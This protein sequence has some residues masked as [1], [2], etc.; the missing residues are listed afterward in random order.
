[1]AVALKALFD[2][3]R[4]AL[5]R[6]RFR[7]WWEGEAFDEGAAVAEIEAGLAAAND[8]A[9]DFDD[10]LFDAPA[11][12]PPPR[13]VAL[14]LLWGE[15]RIRPGDSTADKLEP[16]RIGLAPEGVLAVLGPGHI[17]PLAAVAAAHP[18]QIEVFEWREETFEALKHA[19]A[20]AEL[21]GRI[22]ASRID[23]EAHVFTPNHFDGLLSTD[24]FAY[25]SYP[26]HLAQQIMKCLKPGASAVV[27]CYVGLRIAELPTAF[28]TSFAEPHIRAHGDL[29]QFF[30]DT[31]L[32]L[33]A[34]EDVTEEFLATARQSFS[35]LGEKL[36]SATDFGVMA[37]QELAWEA[38]AWRMRLR[39][40]TQ[41]RLER[42]RFILRKPR[43]DEPAQDETENANAPAG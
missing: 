37:A 6:A 17:G 1:M 27:E 11:Y 21:G 29:L 41:R 9:A 33:E 34:D 30:T 7:A 20:K 38:E 36:S 22:A 43:E 14:S 3:R 31:G 4:L 32:R 2:K 13:L 42:R 12:E 35:Q 15:G 18:G 16:A 25:C 5:T 40:L 23:L 24:D 28:A 10:E 26:P 39:L 8:E 19:I